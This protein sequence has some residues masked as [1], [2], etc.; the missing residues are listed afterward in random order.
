MNSFDL[1]GLALRK[2]CE[3]HRHR[4]LDHLYHLLYDKDHFQID[5]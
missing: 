4:I 1:A 3:I 2:Y 5:Y